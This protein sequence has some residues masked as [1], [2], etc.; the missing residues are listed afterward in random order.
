M[1]TKKKSKYYRNCEG[2]GKPF[3][4]NIS[5]HV[6]CKPTCYPDRI[7]SL[8]RLNNIP[9]GTIGTIAELRV[10]ADLLKKGYE[11]YR[12][13]SQHSSSD[14]VLKKDNRLITVEV[15]TGFLDIRTNKLGYS[16][17]HFRSDMFAIYV[18]TI[19]QITYIPDLINPE[20]EKEHEDKAN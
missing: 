2:C 17:A 13:L 4:T 18:H 6:F 9:S 3:V 10:G 7:G 20:Q 16:K 15:R 1:E 11:V 8:Y 19:D 5:R 14:L 12:A